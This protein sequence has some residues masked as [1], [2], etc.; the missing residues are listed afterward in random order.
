M[1]T[2]G[3]E[4]SGRRRTRR[5]RRRILEGGI[6]GKTLRHAYYFGVVTVKSGVVSFG[7]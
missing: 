1:G 3:E 2:K 5:K 6:G 4:E 7:E